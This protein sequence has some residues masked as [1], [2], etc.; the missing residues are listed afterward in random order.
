[1]QATRRI[2]IVEDDVFI[3]SALTE[4]LESEGYS[5][6]IA[7]NGQE[8][9]DSLRTT[10][11]LPNLILLDWM[12]PIKDGREFRLEQAADSYLAS[13]PVVVMSADYTAEASKLGDLRD[14][15]KK[16]LDVDH[17]LQVVDRS[18]GAHAA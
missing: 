1:M 12:M 3:L 8:A 7:H 6:S 2:L 11:P 18:S 16:P 17:F 14:F 5:V 9:L 13:I 15:L 4:L 10:A